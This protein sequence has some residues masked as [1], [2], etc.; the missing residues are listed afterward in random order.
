MMS[1]ALSGD[2]KVLRIRKRPKETSFKAKTAREPFGNNIIKELFI[3]I[4]INRYNYY[5]G[6][7]NEFNYLIAQNASLYYIKRR[8]AQALEH[9]LLHT[10]LV[11]NYL[12]ALY[13]NMLKPRQINFRS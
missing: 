11:N 12:L 7:I 6:I 4:V 8:G 10:I 13:S 1:S 2:E 3:S 9:W 5:L